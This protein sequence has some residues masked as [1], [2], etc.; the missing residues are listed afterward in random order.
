MN[1]R[2]TKRMMTLLKRPLYQVVGLLECC[3]HVVYEDFHIGE[4]G[5]LWG[6]SHDDV[7]QAAGWDGERGAFIGAAI[8]AG[9]LDIA[10]GEQA[11]ERVDKASTRVDGA[12]MKPFSSTPST[13]MSAST[14]TRRRQIDAQATLPIDGSGDNSQRFMSEVL[15]VH[16]YGERAPDYVTG[17]FRKRRERE[18]LRRLREQEAD[19]MRVDEMSGTVPDIPVV[20]NPTRPDPT[21]PN[22]NIGPAPGSGFV[23]GEDT[24]S[25]RR[26]AEAFVATTALKL[27]IAFRLGEEAMTKQRKAL[28]SMAS[29]AW[30]TPDPTAVANELIRIAEEKA[31]PGTG[32]DNPAAA[33][34]K[35]VKRWFQREGWWRERA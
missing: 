28:R 7:E 8:E 14:S 5:I 4:D 11:V 29:R 2:K 21:Q 27:A 17:R 32:L 15:I 20:P 3:W 23:R 1:H 12:S 34:Q 6:W 25:D 35:A 13:S 16:N 31:R 26:R 10:N 9:F 22:P 18:R 19:A 33:W 30:Q 24:G